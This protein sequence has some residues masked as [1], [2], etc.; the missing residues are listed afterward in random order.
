MGFEGP[1]DCERLADPKRPHSCWPCRVDT[2]ALA[3][4]G[5]AYKTG[6]ALIF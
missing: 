6:H 5:G 3:P 2:F 1:D 4:P